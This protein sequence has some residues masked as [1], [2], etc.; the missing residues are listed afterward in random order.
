MHPTHFAQGRLL[1]G[2]GA[3]VLLLCGGGAAQAAEDV[4]FT[5]GAVPRP[6]PATMAAFW[7]IGGL[8]VIGALATITR[9]NPI[10]AAVCLVGTLFC[11]AGLY[12]L[13]NATF[14]AAM[15]V[16]VYAGAIMVLFVLVVM[17]VEQPEQE[18]TGLLRGTV[19]KIVGL[20]AMALLLLRV[21]V[22]LMGPEVKQAGVVGA[23]YGTVTAMGKLLFSDYLFP[24]EAISLLLLVA[25]VGAV[26][27]S[28]GRASRVGEAAAAAADEGATSATP[29]ADAH[30]RHG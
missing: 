20:V 2:L 9:R 21:V 23:E 29:A 18:E 6:D 25:I 8:T 5:I 24:F 30:G 27:V 19:S 3:L 13:L 14:L 26:T 16:L 7:I 4:T 17:S 11:S 1:A 15:Q 12:L 10:V 22:V 28:R